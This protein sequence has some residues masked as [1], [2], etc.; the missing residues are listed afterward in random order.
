MGTIK[1]FIK[2]NWFKLLALLIFL[3]YI[4][5]NKSSKVIKGTV[6]SSKKKIKKINKEIEVLNEKI[7]D[8]NFYNKFTDNQL[9]KMLRGGNNKKSTD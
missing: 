1:D 4:L 8:S 7:V 9:V 5:L 3:Y 2:K 6:K